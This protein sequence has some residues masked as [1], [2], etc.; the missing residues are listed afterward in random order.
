[1]KIRNPNAYRYRYDDPNLYGFDV[2]N[3]AGQSSLPQALAQHVRISHGVLPQIDAVLASV[4]TDLGLETPFTGFVYASAETNA[5]CSREPDGRVLVFI[6]SALVELLS[7]MEM[8][9]VVGH[10]FAHAHFAH[11]RYPSTVTGEPD[12]RRLELSR[13][14]EV[15]ADRLGVACCQSTDHAIRA[16]VKTAAG[17][18]DAHLEFDLVEYLRQGTA[19]RNEP[20]PSLAWS[21]HPPLILRARAALRFDSILHGERAGDDFTIRLR[22]LDDEIFDELDIA[23][24]GPE[25]S[26]TARDAAFWTVASR[27]CSDGALDDAEQAR[28][29]TIFGPDRVDALRRMLAAETQHEALA[30]ID[31]RLKVTQDE[32]EAGSIAA[33]RRYEELVANFKETR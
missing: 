2:A 31:Q 20:D 12:Q 1:M 33:Q 19:L 29:E 32:L 11:H 17:L 9:F 22:N 26:Q 5:Q 15:S 13:A 18:S 14:A 3:S 10:E 4:S 27:M 28:M 21:T 8:C 25:G 16:I 30:L 7:P 6:S 24:H 23:A